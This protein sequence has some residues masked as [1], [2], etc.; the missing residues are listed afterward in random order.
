[1]QTFAVIEHESSTGKTREVLDRVASRIGWIP[2]MIKLMA[3]S[4]AATEA[5]F[6]FNVA[7]AEASLPQTTRVLILAAVADAHG[8]AYSRRIAAGQAKE[9]GISDQALARAFDGHADD[10]TVAAVLRFARDIAHLR[11]RVAVARVDDLRRVGCT[12]GEIVEIVATVALAVFRDYFNL[13]AGTPID[14]RAPTV[15][16]PK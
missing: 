12:D 6:N 3:N 14:A 1:M 15:D 11:G 4:P 2:G 16:S 5:Y 7:M 13:V 10:K 8:C 9:L